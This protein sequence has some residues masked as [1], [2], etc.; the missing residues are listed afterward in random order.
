MSASARREIHYFFS[1][2]RPTRR[3]VVCDIV[4]ELGGYSVS[5]QDTF[6]YD[7]LNKKG[8]GPMTIHISEQTEARVIEEARRQ[9]ISVEA[10]IE[11][12]INERLGNGGPSPAATGAAL[13]EVLRA[14]PYPDI[15][16]TPHRE[17][18]RSS[19]LQ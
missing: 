11:K 13:L 19:A 2:A 10:L 4:L 6:T 1:I 16:L 15:D 5:M 9:G 17:R 3:V 18:V 14:S 8:G 12:L 7:T